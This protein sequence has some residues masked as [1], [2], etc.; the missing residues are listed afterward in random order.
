MSVFIS[1][2]IIPKY[3]NYT[4]NLAENQFTH[5]ILMPIFLY[6]LPIYRYVSLVESCKTIVIFQWTTYL[7][8]HTPVFIDYYLVM[9]AYFFETTTTTRWSAPPP[10]SPGCCADRSCQTGGSSVQWQQEGRQPRW[11]PFDARTAAVL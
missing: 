1:E 2:N 11:R 6:V 3:V 8:R 4:L 7:L 5:W 9:A 10:A